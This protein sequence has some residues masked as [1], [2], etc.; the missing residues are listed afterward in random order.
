MLSFVGGFGCFQVL[1]DI[2]FCLMMLPA[3]Y[4]VLIMYFAAMTPTWTCVRNSSMCIAN[5]TY[6]NT[7]MSRCR[8][9]K[10]EWTY[11]QSKGLSIVSTFDLDCERQWLTGLTTSVFF[12]G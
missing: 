4:Q 1:L 10:S 2:I 8:I 7:D 9:P 5:V 6:P 11:T 12:L 3:S